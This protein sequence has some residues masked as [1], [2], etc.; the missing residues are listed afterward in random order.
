M[1]VVQYNNDFDK[2]PRCINCGSPAHEGYEV[3]YIQVDVHGKPTG[4]ILTCTT[5]QSK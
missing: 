5:Y 4:T 2:K 3:Q 1:A